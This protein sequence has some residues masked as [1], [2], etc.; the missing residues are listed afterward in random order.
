MDEIK[1]II[2][3]RISYMTNN[4]VE[5]YFRMILTNDYFE[6]YKKHKDEIKIHVK[7][8]D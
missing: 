4:G 3:S 1:V 6:N 2:S 5:G 8:R 7:F